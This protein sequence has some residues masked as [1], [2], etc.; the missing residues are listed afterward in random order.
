MLWCARVLVVVIVAIFVWIM[1]RNI[2]CSIGIGQN[3]KDYDTLLPD[4]F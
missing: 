4:D 2:F 1:T 3:S